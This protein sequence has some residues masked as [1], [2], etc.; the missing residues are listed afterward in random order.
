MHETIVS[1][2][3]HGRYLS[4]MDFVRPVE[5]VVG[6]VQGHLLAVLVKIT[7]PL[8]LRRLASLAG[9]SPAQA[10]RVMP[11]LV[12]LGIVERHEVPPASQFVLARDNIAAQAILSLADVHSRMLHQIGESAASISPNPVSVVV[13]GSFA[14]SAADSES[15]IDVLV[16]RHDD[17]SDEDEKWSDSLEAWRLRLRAVAGNDVELVEATAS[18]A[19][20]KLRGRSELWRDI[21]TEGLTVYGE[22]IDKLAQSRAVREAQ[23]QRPHHA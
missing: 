19:A 14:R 16:V 11:R 18:E 12:E 6:G 15:D 13:F 2:M 21:R 5:S 17:V 22:P 20:R 23:A 10:S 3:R 1:F 8:T 9:V 7:A 4:A